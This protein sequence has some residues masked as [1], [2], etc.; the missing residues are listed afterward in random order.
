MD[1]LETKVDRLETRFDKLETKVDRLETRFDKRTKLQAKQRLMGLKQTCRCKDYVIG[2][3]AKLNEHDILKR[4]KIQV[5][6][7][8]P[9][10]Q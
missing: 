1:R 6:P 10:Y 2:V 7:S 5:I 4:V 9:S 8:N 3:D